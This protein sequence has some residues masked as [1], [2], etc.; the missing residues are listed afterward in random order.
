MGDRGIYDSASCQSVAKM[1]CI[2]ANLMRLCYKFRHF[3]PNLPNAADRAPLIVQSVNTLILVAEALSDG[4]D[5]NS[6]DHLS[7]LFDQFAEP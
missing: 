2:V 4:D 1:V 7:P 5:P 6:L 3:N